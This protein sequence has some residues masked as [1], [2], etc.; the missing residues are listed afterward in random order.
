M[1]KK[2]FQFVPSN[3]FME[4]AEQL[5]KI[6]KSF[7]TSSEIV[8][9]NLKCIKLCLSKNYSYPQ[10]AKLIF[11]PNGCNISGASI[12]REYEKI[13]SKPPTPKSKINLTNPSEVKDEN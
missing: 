13:Q 1:A 9:Q 11:K 12:K 3:K 5:P 10:I 2:L 7:V 6:E 4:L 8:K